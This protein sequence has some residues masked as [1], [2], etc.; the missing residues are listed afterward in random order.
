MYVIIP[1][2]NAEKTVGNCIDSL[3][4][5]DYDNLQVVV[6]N[7]GSKDDTLKILNE[8]ARNNQNVVV[9]DKPNGGVSSARNVALDMIMSEEEHCGYVSFVDADDWVEPWFVSTLVAL[10]QNEH[11][12]M[13]ACGFKW[14]RRIKRH[15][16]KKKKSKV[17]Q[18][19]KLT[20]INE[21][22]LDR[23]LFVPLW[24]KLF[25][26]E[27]IGNLR[28]D[29]SLKF[30]EDLA[31]LIEYLHGLPVYATVS[32]S[33]Q[34]CYHYIR[35][36]G[37]LSLTSSYKNKLNAMNMHLCMERLLVENYT[38]EQVRYA[39]AW[40]FCILV[41]FLFFAK[42]NKDKDVFEKVKNRMA[43]IRKDYLQLK[44]G[45]VFWRRFGS[46]IFKLIT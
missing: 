19:D 7:D 39:H 16:A 1:A 42:R 15:F 5:Q 45:Y 27:F 32:Y 41:E 2:Y 21:V 22:F 11:C 36:K 25:C 37:S 34:K 20:A 24:N 17:L 12:G 30:G 8:Y 40:E 29:G 31:F 35:T 43:Q 9:I 10:A 4:K 38:E 26:T 46:V 6:V 3:L 14:Q 13:T 18:F 28:F 44:N 23:Y 33:S